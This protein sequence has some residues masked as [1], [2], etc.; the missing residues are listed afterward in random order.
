MTTAELAYALHCC[1]TDE[2]LPLTEDE[3]ERAAVAVIRRI[4]CTAGIPSALALACRP[5][6]ERLTR[7]MNVDHYTAF[8]CARFR[9]ARE[10]RQAREELA[11]P[12]RRKSHAVRIGG[13]TRLL[14]HAG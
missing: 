3:R 14:I 2:S 10:Q 4:R 7:D 9:L 11:P 1:A 6:V 8:R 12:A 5:D 13:E